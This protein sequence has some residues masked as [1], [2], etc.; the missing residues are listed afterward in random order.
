MPLKQPNARMLARASVRKAINEYYR[1]RADD[2]RDEEDQD[3]EIDSLLTGS[4]SLGQTVNILH[5][6]G[7]SDEKRNELMDSHYTD[8]PRNDIRDD[9]PYITPAD[10][11]LGSDYDIDDSRYERR[12]VRASLS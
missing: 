4:L 1:E 3:L 5:I 10:A 6:L 2:A 12:V 11:D 8:D 9:E 7:L